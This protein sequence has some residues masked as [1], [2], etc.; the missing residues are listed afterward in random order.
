MQLIP[1]SKPDI[2]QKD[3]KRVENTIKS[4]WLAHGKNSDELEN[5]FIKF[6]GTKYS[7]TISNCTSGIHA[8]CM[9]LGL[10]S[11][12]EVIV[13]AQTHVATAHAAAM[14]GAKIKFADVDKITGN[15]LFEEIKKL[16]TKKQMFNRCSYDRLSM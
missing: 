3:L 9:A 14:T 10:N 7:T 2:K 13:P 11:S 4:G 15:I 6:T 1:F 8:V 16:K 12:H 5:Q